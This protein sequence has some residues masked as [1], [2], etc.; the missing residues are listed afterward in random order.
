MTWR[1]AQVS[2]QLEAEERL[3]FI[4]RYAERRAAA[5]ENA[6]Y[7]ATVEALSDHRSGDR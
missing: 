3:G 4:Q 5:E 7:A 2:L 1:E 6:A